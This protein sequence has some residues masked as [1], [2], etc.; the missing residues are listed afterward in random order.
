MICDSVT[1]ECV[2]KL[3]VMRTQSLIIMAMIII[4]LAWCMWIG[5]WHETHDKDRGTDNRDKDHRHVEKDK[6]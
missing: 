2:G 6:R 5:W 3:S 1:T 4:F